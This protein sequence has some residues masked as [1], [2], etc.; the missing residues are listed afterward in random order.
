MTNQ[1]AHERTPLACRIKLSHQSI[2]DVVGRTRDISQGGIF[3]EQE[4]SHAPPVGAIVSGQ[5][6]G[7][8]IDS[9]VMQMEV[10]RIASEGLGLRFL[11]RPQD[12]YVH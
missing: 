7:L 10:V 9:P 2:G 11:G 5:V 12:D 1:R 4:P 6:Q 3:V 8:V